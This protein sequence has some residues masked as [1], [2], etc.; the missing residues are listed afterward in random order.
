MYKIRHK[1]LE[2]KVAAVS[3][4]LLHLETNFTDGINLCYCTLVIMLRPTL[5]T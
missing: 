3:E 1:K 2:E 4:G 5:L